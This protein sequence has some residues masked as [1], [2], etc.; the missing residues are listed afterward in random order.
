MCLQLN[1]GPGCARPST[2]HSLQKSSLWHVLASNRVS[3]ST[4]APRS[5]RSVT[6]PIA[7]RHGTVS[8]SF[9][10]ADGDKCVAPSLFFLKKKKTDKRVLHS[11]IGLDKTQ[12]NT[13]EPDKAPTHQR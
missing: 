3:S 11:E 12:I 4:V 5:R 13:E 8:W 2:K 7:R 10:S 1:R 9:L 6:Q